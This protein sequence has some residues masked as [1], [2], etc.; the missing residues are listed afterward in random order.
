MD[1]ASRSGEAPHTRGERPL[2]EQNNMN[3]KI[4]GLMSVVVLAGP[5]VVAP[6]NASLVGDTVT[7]SITPTPFWVCDNPTAVVGAG[8]E[9]ELELPAAPN[10][11]GLLV[12]LGASSIRIANAEDNLFGLGAGELLTLGSL[13]LG[14]PIVGISNFL[15]S[16][17]SVINLA[18]ISWTSDSVSIDLDSGAGWEVG[19]WASF[20]LVYKTP[21][22][23]SL[24]LL[25]LGL[26]GLG[27]SRR[28][29]A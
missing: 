13:D 6:A 14:G 23:G 5:L 19:S 17:V 1:F 20:D 18:S 9:F 2:R 3:T 10:S 27:L 26:A 8:D 16:G 22:P 4:L 29:K 28:R 25:G 15:V 21:E 11:F 7:C 24:A 12:D